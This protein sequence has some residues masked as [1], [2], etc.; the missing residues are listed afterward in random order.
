MASTRFV[1]FVVKVSKL[2]NLR[3]KYCYEY[4]HLGDR[5]AMTLDQLR[6]L[7]RNVAHYYRV[8]DARD[9]QRTEIRIIWH[10]GEPLL[11][12]P[13]FFWETFADQLEIFGADLERLNLV[14]TNLVHLDDARIDLL[15]RG[16]DRIGISCDLF[17][18][19]RVDLG[20]RC[21]QA[22][23][24]ANMRRL[25]Q[26]GIDFGVISVLSGANIGKV[27]QIFDY[28]ARAK[29]GFRLL[30]L[31]DGAWAGQHDGHDLTTHD[32]LKAYCRVFE[33]WLEAPEFV[34]VNPIVEHVQ[35]V[36]R[37]FS[38]DE[39]RRFFR[40]RDWVPTVLVDTDGETY[41]YGDPYGEREWSYGN[42]FDT[43]YDAMLDSPVF[44]RSA[45]ESERRTAENC[46]SCVYF[47]ACDGYPIAEDQS[48]CREKHAN[49]VR[50]CVLERG[51]MTYVELRL[52]E[53]GY[54]VDDRLVLTPE[55]AEKLGMRR[56]S[57][58]KADASQASLPR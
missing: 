5:R 11:Q 27:E 32:V 35:S 41:G 30:P 42:V 50:R 8:M 16:F 54:I 25:R 28:W 44:N 3:C 19:L 55:Q 7:Y 20:Q 43:R 45:V 14:Q 52:R 38:R 49:G 47:G 40:K 36:L 48:N 22:T 15:R 57:S 33:M 21:R 24:F 26:V 12:S 58:E 4:P 17:G 56:A 29:V 34:F 18:G 10:G 37:R 2:C 6:R 13:D 53:R 1:Q 46:L 9:L 23:V 39:R 31:F 51:F